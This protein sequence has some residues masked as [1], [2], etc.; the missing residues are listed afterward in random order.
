MMTTNTIFRPATLCLSLFGYPC[1]GWVRE[2]CSVA[3]F[4]GFLP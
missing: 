3:I 2:R 4:E 1:L